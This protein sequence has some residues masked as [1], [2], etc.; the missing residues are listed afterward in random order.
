MFSFFFVIRSMLFHSTVYWCMLEAVA[1]CRL[2]GGKLIADFDARLG[3]STR[4]IS[5]SLLSVCRSSSSRRISSTAS[6]SPISSGRPRRMQLM[7]RQPVRRHAKP[8]RYTLCPMCLAEEP[9][10]QLTTAKAATAGH[11]P[12]AA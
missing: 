12:S 5:P 8:L 1:R 4:W 11:L 9:G 3:P 6:T 7:S 2:Q 10:A